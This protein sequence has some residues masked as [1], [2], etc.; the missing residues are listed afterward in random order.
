MTTLKSF[1]MLQ[2]HLMRANMCL[3]CRFTTSPEKPTDV[4]LQFSPFVQRASVLGISICCC[5][6][7][8]SM[9]ETFA[10]TKLCSIQ[11]LVTLLV[12]LIYR[13]GYVVII[14]HLVF[15]RRNLEEITNC[16]LKVI[17]PQQTLTMTNAGLYLIIIIPSLSCA[18]IAYPII[19]RATK[20]VEWYMYP[21]V[22]NRDFLYPLCVIYFNITL[23]ILSNFITRKTLQVFFS[24]AKM[25]RA[26]IIKYKSLDR[27]KTRI[28][29]RKSIQLDDSQTNSI[30][31]GLE[32]V[33]RALNNLL[34]CFRLPTATMVATDMVEIVYSSAD[35]AS[36]KHSLWGSW[37]YLVA[38]IVRISINLSSP[39]QFKTAVHQVRET[40]LIIKRR[41]NK[42]SKPELTKALEIIDMLPSFSCYGLFTLGPH[43]FLPL[44][45]TCIT[46]ALVSFQDMKD[47]AT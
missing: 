5:I 6:S 22:I 1:F 36:G 4:K 8:T 46:F 11:S 35:I 2:L 37:P 44:L 14:M 23:Q 19:N 43:A 18:F 45:S 12:T 10:R 34:N 47:R 31:I 15:K 21:I 25:R 39:A 17:S 40:L 16:L 41:V 32:L 9:L 29:G 38:S 28:R 42:S 13:L 20:P 33:E 7:L 27:L 26:R 30:I 24:T 3:P